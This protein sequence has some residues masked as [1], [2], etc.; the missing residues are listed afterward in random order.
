[1]PKRDGTGPYSGEGKRMGRLKG[2]CKPEKL[3]VEDRIR[4]AYYVNERLK[5]QKRKPSS[6]FDEEEERKFIKRE[7]EVLGMH[8]KELGSNDRKAIMTMVEK[9][10]YEG[11]SYWTKNQRMKGIPKEVGRV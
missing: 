4:L 3:S 2:D 9:I 5:M 7:M 6:V 8:G 10:Y 11:A 1:M